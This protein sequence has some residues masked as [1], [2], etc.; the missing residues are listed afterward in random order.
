MRPS[1]AGSGRERSRRRR[2]RH[3]VSGVI[4]EHLLLL[5]AVTAALAIAALGSIPWS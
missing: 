1:Q 5:V 2:R 4:R 3:D